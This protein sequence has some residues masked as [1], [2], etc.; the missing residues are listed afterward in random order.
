MPHRAGLILGQNPHCTELKA[1]Q[2]PGDCP[3]VM[4]GFEIDWYISA[5]HVCIIVCIINSCYLCCLIRPVVITKTLLN[6]R[7]LFESPPSCL[8]V[9]IDVLL[10]ITALDFSRLATPFNLNLSIYL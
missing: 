3:G 10:T 7:P 9:C 4:G 6:M 1:S 2:M 5:M 8:K